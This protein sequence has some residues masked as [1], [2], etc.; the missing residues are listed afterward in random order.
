M[1]RTHAILLLAIA[2]PAGLAAAQSLPA[3]PSEE[4]ARTRQAVGRLLAEGKLR[5][6]LPLVERLAAICRQVNGERSIHYADSL[7]NLAMLHLNLGQAQQ[8]KG[9]LVRGLAIRRA[10]PAGQQ[11]DIALTLHRLGQ[12]CWQTADY[13]GAASHLLEALDGYR[14]AHGQAAPQVAKCMTDLGGLYRE[15]GRAHKAEESFAGALNLARK[16]CGPTG[17]GLAPYLNNLALVYYDAAAYD[18]AEPLLK[19]SLAAQQAA[20]GEQH[21]DVA[22]AQSNL[23]GLYQKMGTY[24]QAEA[25]YA[26]ALATR[27]KHFGDSHPAVAATRHNLASLRYDV[28]AYEGAKS[29]AAAALAA[30]QKAFGRHHPAVASTLN[31]LAAV[32]QKLGDLAQAEL[33]YKEALAIREKALGGE[34]PAVGVCLGNLASLY[35]ATGRHGEAAPLHAKALRIAEKAYGPDHPAL[36]PALSNIAADQAA[37]GR[38][39]Q[40]LQTLRRARSIVEKQT[41]VVLGFTS[42]RTKLAFLYQTQGYRDMLVSMIG[43]DP[44]ADRQAVALAAEWL[45]R[46][47][48]LAL[49]SLHVQREAS[50]LSGKPN[51]LA[52]VRELNDVRQRL[53]GLTFSGAAA[54]RAGG[55]DLASLIRRKEDLEGRIAR[56][57][58]PFAQGLM[59]RKADLASVAAALPAGS[60]LVDFDRPRTFRFEPK[61]GEDDW[62]DPRYVAFVVPAGRPQ[63]TAMVD[64]G[65]AKAIDE[66][67]LAFRKCVTSTEGAFR[68][69]RVTVLRQDAR[70][71]ARADLEHKSLRL[72]ELAFRPLEEHLGQA[73][74]VLISPEGSLAVIPFES[75][76]DEGKAFLVERYAFSYVSAGRD[77]IDCARPGRPT[78][79]GAVIGAHP[80]FDRSRAAGT[81][82]SSAPA[83]GPDGLDPGAGGLRGLHF[84]PLPGTAKECERVAAL[85]SSRPAEVLTEAAACESAVRKIKAPRVLHIATHGFFLR[86]E[87][88]APA[89]S[90]TGS[91]FGDGLVLRSPLLYSGLAM[92]GAN[93]RA[94]V[95]G[96]SDDGVLTALEVAG[97]DLRGTELVT[98]SACETGLG[99]QRRGE[100]VFGLRRAFLQAGAR[101]L[102]MSMWKVPDKETVSLM[103]TFY[104]AWQSGKGKAAALREAQLAMIAD[105]RK[106][107]H[108]FAHPFFWAGFVLIGDWDGRGA[109]TAP[110]G[111]PATGSTGE[112]HA[113]DDR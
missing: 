80:D 35:D 18:R 30:E 24:D 61:R 90:R 39:P 52:A 70:Q 9:L 31:L 57:S 41:D 102:V 84:D 25:L 69:L 99:L 88:V 111:P 81:Q 5:Q 105:L 83:A 78:A 75:L 12:A 16:L 40:A 91:G 76:L 110:P 46:S 45:L 66:A 64:L 109:T 6:A 106:R 98:L 54:H 58:R 85:L 100:G 94:Q 38:T 68:G 37:R 53:A 13:S 89:S 65:E 34:H 108:G 107:P 14:K 101:S 43:R 86:R 51:L 62:G 36:L 67:V 59:V 23:A 17:E 95:G 72:Y 1:G 28:G 112:N 92:A 7:W 4:V 49:E 63:A 60:A 32:H 47:K 29:L 3:D 96:A 55:G 77:V 113:N 33:L 93:R 15:T 44:T 22:T 79:A 73:R 19:E 50:R 27:R 74:R 21:P 2:L 104:G 56:D 71:Q 42:E 20:H 82:P 87:D 48:A 8:A 11:A 10:A 26:Q 97:L 103:A